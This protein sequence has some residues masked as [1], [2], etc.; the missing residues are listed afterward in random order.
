MDRELT[1]ISQLGSIFNWSF[2]EFVAWTEAANCQATGGSLKNG[3]RVQKGSR[4]LVVTPRIATDLLGLTLPKRSVKTNVK[5]EAPAP[6]E[7]PRV[8][9]MIGIYD[10][11]RFDKLRTEAFPEMWSKLDSV[12]EALSS[13]ESP[14][15]LPRMDWFAWPEW[16]RSWC[17]HFK[18]SPSKPGFRDYEYIGLGMDTV[19]HVYGLFRS[20]LHEDN[21][22]W[23]YTFVG[24]RKA[25]GP[26]L[27]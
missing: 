18:S 16:A 24:Y 19:T 20:R 21:A 15:E 26:T 1:A 13:V 2:V 22:P 17:L 6:F 25:A 23:V 11:K 3:V 5:V 12:W 14:H 10:G 9:W 7:L 8:E 27:D 4:S